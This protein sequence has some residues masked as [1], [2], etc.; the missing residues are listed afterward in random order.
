MSDIAIAVVNYNGERFLEACVES[1]LNQ[2][3]APSEVLVI[4]NGSTDGSVALMRR[5]FPQVRLIETGENLFFCRG[6]N[7]C[8]A[9][10]I[11][12]FLL[13]LNNDAVLE[14]DYARLA[15]EAMLRD[16]RIGAVSGKIL[17][18]DRE[19]LDTAGQELSRSRKPLDRGWGMPDDGRFDVDEEVFGAGG[20]A[21][22]LRRSMLNDVALDGQVFDEG[23]VQYYEDLDLMW[24]A[25]NLGWKAWYVPQ[26]VAYHHRG[27]VGQSDP[28]QQTWVRRFAFANL[29]RELQRHLLKNRYAAMA[30][31]DRLLSWLAGLPWILLYELKIFAYLLLIRPSLIPGYF[32]GF[33]FLR[34]AFAAR[35]QLK[36]MVRERGIRRYG[37][38]HVVRGTGSGGE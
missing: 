25:R 15:L 17:R 23:F 36:R 7:F 9:E 1:A 19:T 38:R 28:A 34:Q 18:A 14:P 8:I 35:K 2:K 29:P 20:V 16:E 10:T 11:A 12:P 13:L 6:A 27:G 24:R 22:L 26:A 4:D 33:G 32:K 30:K 31:N 37:G 21:P 5:R 3:P